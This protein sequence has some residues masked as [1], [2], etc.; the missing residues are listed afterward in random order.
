MAGPRTRTRT[1]P[2]AMATLRRAGLPAAALIL[3]GFFG[4]Y[5]VLGPNGPLAF[6]TDATIDETNAP[7][8]VRPS[9]IVVRASG[10]DFTSTLSLA[11]EQTT[12]TRS[13]EGGVGSGLDFLQMRAVYTVRARVGERTID[14]TAP[15]SAETFR[16]PR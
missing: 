4:Y 2:N 14:F 8:D 7:G 16:G 5:A 6:S 3:M 11:I 9:R 1:K 13:R 10:E 12:L 15:G